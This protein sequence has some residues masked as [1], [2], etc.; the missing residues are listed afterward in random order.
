MIATSSDVDIA[1]LDRMITNSGDRVSSDDSSRGNWEGPK[2]WGPYVK[3]WFNSVSL[4]ILYMFK[5]SC[6][7][8]S[9][10]TFG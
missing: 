6:R 4:S 10:Q 9:I 2:E 1:K 8:S 5:P 3:H 7:P